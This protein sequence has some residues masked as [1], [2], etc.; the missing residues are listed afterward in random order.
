MDLR[1]TA[2]ASKEV[3][4]TNFMVIGL[5]RLRIKADSTA[6]EAGALSTRPSE[7]L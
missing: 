3:V 5:I 7:L 1:T 6:P 2:T 4:N